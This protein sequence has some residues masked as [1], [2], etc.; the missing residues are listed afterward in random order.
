M[1]TAH[2]NNGQP[3]EPE[4]SVGETCIIYLVRH[5]TPDWN[6]RDIPYHLPPGP[7]LTEQGVAEAQ[8]LA[9]FL[10]QAGVGFLI[11]SPLERC[12]HTAQIAATQSAVEVEIDP[13]LQELQPGE[14]EAA[15]LAR[16]L[17][18]VQKTL[19]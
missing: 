11:T 1:D 12:Q 17:P 3:S 16:V 14:T 10:R 7:P 2:R 6:R 9:A 19:I 4:C 18:V 13:A 5:A 15:V 8:A